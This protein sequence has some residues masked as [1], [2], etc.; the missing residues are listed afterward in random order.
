MAIVKSIDNTIK[1]SEGVLSA[2]QY[3]TNPEKVFAVSC[4]NCFGESTELAKQFFI[5]RAAF[6]KNKNILAHHYVQSFSPEDNISPEQAH[7]IGMELI[8]K[9]AP[10]YQVVLGTH[11]DKGHI[12]NH[13][14]INSCNVKTGYKWHS[15]KATLENIRGESDTL[16][17]KNDLSVIKERGKFKGIDQTTYQLAKKGKSW[18]VNLVKH[19][20]EA[21]SV[22]KSKDD[23]LKFLLDK[24]YTV[25]LTGSNITVTKNGEKKGIRLDTL[26]KQFG[27]KYSKENIEK[28]F[29]SVHI[30]QRKSEA[31]GQKKKEKVKPLIKTEWERFEEWSFKKS[32][33]VPV[34][35]SDKKVSESLKSNPQKFS[36]RIYLYNLLKNRFSKKKATAPIIDWNR[37]YTTKSRELKEAEK[38]FYMNTTKNIGNIPYK[39]LTSVQGENY[40]IKLSADCITKLMN[41]PIFYSG[42][43]D[44]KTGT[45]TITIKE[46][47]KELLRSFLGACDTIVF[48]KQNEAIKNREC[49]NKIKTQAK[50]NNEKLEYMVVTSEQMELLKA[51]FVEF[52]YF[53]KEDKFNIAFL[54][55]SKDRV[56]KILFPV[57][58]KAETEFQKNNRINN[59]LKLWQLSIMKS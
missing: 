40:K 13:F 34:T 38:S 49:Y 46:K 14:I 45:V 1:S 4:E 58:Q 48:D 51:E 35:F 16:C 28:K 31:V 10:G 27:P 2:I 55:K 21:L 59:E 7:Q 8:K 30:H 41:K 54:P 36:L 15:N 52:S 18:K 11:I 56:K 22:C 44:I 57:K 42:R 9:V 39:Q 3:I 23:F 33:I 24:D 37:T 29:G 53:Q 43:L 6:G 47:D 17:R 20:D 26:S 19:L 25:K 32:E 12:H 50:S 5:T